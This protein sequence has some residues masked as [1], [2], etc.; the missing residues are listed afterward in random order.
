MAAHGH[1]QERLADLIRSEVA[2]MI[3][4]ELHD[5]RIGFATVMRVE[6]SADLHHAR[7]LVSVLG[8]EEEQQK[9]LAGLSS[10]A[11]YVRR[12]IGQRLRLRRAPDLIFVLDRGVEEGQKIETLLQKV[13]DQP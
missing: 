3:A 12:A 11:R 9:T 8:N 4:G 2:D 7:V 1:R 6:L 10:A 5:P 13:K